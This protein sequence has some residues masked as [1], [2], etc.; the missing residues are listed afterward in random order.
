VPTLSE[1]L[2]RRGLIHQMTNPAELGALLDGPGMVGYIGFDPTADSLHVGHLQQICLLRR[3]ELAGHRPIALVGGGTGMIGDPAGNSEERNLLDAPTIAHNSAAVAAQ[4][5]HF[6]DFGGAGS[7]LVDNIDWLGAVGLIE[8]LRE[9]G[10]HF[11]VNEMVRKDSV[12]LRLA[13]A[14]QT[15]SFTEF[16]YMLL[17]AWDFVQL[18]DRLGCRLQLG[19]SDQWGNITEGIDLVRRCRGAQVFGLTS[20]LVTKADGAKFA[21]TATGTIW[22]DGGRTSPYQF[23]QFWLGAADSE[24]S[25]YLRRFT[26]LDLDELD[27]L[28]RGLLEHPE[29]RDAQRTLARHV[30]ALVHGSAEAAGAERAAQVLFTEDVARLDLATLTSALADA[31]TTLLAS[32][33]LAGMDLVDV[34]TRSGLSPSRRDAR[35]QLLAG[36]ISVNNRR[37]GEDS[38]LTAED[39][40]HGRYVLLRRGRRT[41]HVL[42]VD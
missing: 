39:A 27:E 2:R 41:M 21:K 4:L 42:R 40:L 8:F 16:S 17:M 36:A 12:R 34:L 9:V 32:D 24:A 10:K 35:Q 18:Y 19:G 14:G 13:G 3:L 22:L 20:P 37:R 6:L 29:R 7:E 38:T 5:G 26:F 1:D 33:D 25:S 23:F 11:S 28:D 31:P 30:T 15:L